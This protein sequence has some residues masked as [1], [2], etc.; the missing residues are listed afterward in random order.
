MV[1]LWKEVEV[2]V[3]V[4]LS[5]FDTED[6]ISELE[7][8]NVS[9]TGPNS[10]TAGEI[11]EKLHIAYTLKQTNQIDGLLRDLFYQA[12]GRIV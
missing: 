8:R 9:W 4:D 7:D 10:S 11:I 6:L 5:D 3:E 2:E 12:L 1:T